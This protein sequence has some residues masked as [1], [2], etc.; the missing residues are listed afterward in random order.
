[1]VLKEPNLDFFEKNGTLTKDAQFLLIRHGQS[2]QNLM[3]V[4][5]NELLKGLEGDEYKKKC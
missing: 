4:K 5:N 3:S 1:M 2:Y